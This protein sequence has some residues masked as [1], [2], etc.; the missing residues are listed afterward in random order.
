[1]NRAVLSK[2]FDRNTIDELKNDTHAL[3]S[4]IENQNDGTIIYTLEKLGRLENGYSRDPLLNLLKKPNEKIRSLSIKNLAKIGD[5]SLL[6]IFVRHA[7]EDESTEVRREAVSAIG[8]LRNKET[9]PI[10]CNYLQDQDPKVVMQAI[11]GLLVFSNES[12]IK[13]KLKQLENHPN[14]VIKEVIS[15]ELYG[16]S[17]KSTSTQ[18]HDEFPSYMKNM[19]VHGDV[20]ETIKYIPDESIH[21]TFT[22]PPYYNARDYSIYQS[23]EEYLQFLEQVFKEVHRIT[24]EGRFFVLNT[25]PIIIPRIS[26]AH[27]SKR[28]PIPY[29]IHPLLIKMGW[30]FIDDIVWV[31]PEAS[32]KNR[33]AGFLQHR[34][35]LGYKPNAITESL[36]VYRKKT[37]KLI[38]WNIKQYSW[39][40][41][42]RSK[43]EEKYE[44]TNVWQIDPTFDKV[45]SAVFPKE[46]CDRV[47]KYYSFVDD[48]VFDPFAGSGTVGKSAIKLDRNFFLTEKEEKYVLRMKDDLMKNQDLFSN[49]KKQPNFIT[50]NDFISLTNSI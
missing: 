24:K 5:L 36:M 31:K 35:P 43:V 27:S 16:S 46:L 37:D 50:T 28:Y 42:K 48:L 21:L 39:E 40:K 38:D 20:Q 10:L 7:S 6:T 23:Y 15:K 33:N 1:M 22:S 13:N 45:H 32:V 12:E 18:K 9:V 17:Y 30:E 44:T 26:R 14:E 11:R 34:K 49:N 4:F 19:V 29:D 41:V 47:I 8:R 25:S 3:L 2:T